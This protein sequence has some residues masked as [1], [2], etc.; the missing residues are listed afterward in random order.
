[1]SRYSYYSG[2]GGVEMAIKAQSVDKS[3][4]ILTLKINIVGGEE[5]PRS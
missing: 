5:N 4:N 1:M 2:Y 3:I